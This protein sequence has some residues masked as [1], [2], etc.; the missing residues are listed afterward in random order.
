MHKKHQKLQKNAKNCHDVKNCH[1]FIFLYGH[2]SSLVLVESLSAS[3]NDLYYFLHLSDNTLLCHWVRQPV[4]WLTV[5]V[6]ILVG[7]LIS[8]LE[9]T[10]IY[11]FWTEELLLGNKLL[12]CNPLI[13]TSTGN[14][15]LCR[16]T[17]IS[18]YIEIMEK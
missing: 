7:C 15:F 17:E 16:Y 4:W 3:G 18:I 11:L 10:M 8:I 14:K 13:S 5:I 2:I 6:W 1:L 9:F 12:Q